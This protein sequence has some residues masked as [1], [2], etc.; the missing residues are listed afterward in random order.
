VFRSHQDNLR[1]YIVCAYLVFR[2]C[3]VRNSVGVLA[4][5]PCFTL[6]EDFTFSQ[7]IMQ[8]LCKLLSVVNSFKLYRQPS[9]EILWYMESVLCLF[10]FFYLVCEAIG[11][12]ATP[13]L[14]CQPR[15]I[16]KM[17]VEKQM[18]CR[19]AGETEVLGENLPC[20][21]TLLSITK[22]HMTRPGF[23]PG[24]PRWE[25]GDYRSFVFH[26]L[27]RILLDMFWTR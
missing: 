14:L 5:S 22:S 27:K 20:P 23:E 26:W 10:V 7:Y 21:A 3:P 25:V 9:H 8:L 6:L 1:Q 24:P 12:A 11:T 15:L 18:E 4:I 19:L 2:S 17:I 16:V 13:D